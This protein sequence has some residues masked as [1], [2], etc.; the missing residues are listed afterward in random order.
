MAIKKP[1]TKPPVNVVASSLGY[2]GEYIGRGLAW[3]SEKVISELA[4]PMA[5]LSA[6]SK[7]SYVE[8]GLAGVT[9]TLGSIKFGI[10]SYISNEGIRDVVNGVTLDVVES[11]GN[12]ATNIKDEPEKTLYVAIGTYGIGKSIPFLSGKIRKKLREKKKL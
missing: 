7:G 9:K 4:L 5:L 2:M 3:T 11:V 12:I 6:T 10:K 8:R 1:G